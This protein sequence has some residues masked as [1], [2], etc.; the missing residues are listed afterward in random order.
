MKRCDQEQDSQASFSTFPF[1][2]YFVAVNT[3][4]ISLAIS[5]TEHKEW[6]TEVNR[7]TVRK[8]DFMPEAHTLLGKRAIYK[9]HYRCLQNTAF[10]ETVH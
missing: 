2:F 1:N 4:S 6:E 5:I 9:R 8:T 3:L 10:L 7:S